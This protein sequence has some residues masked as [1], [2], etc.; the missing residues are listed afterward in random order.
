MEESKL[1]GF[2]L[3]LL[4]FGAAV[5]IAEIMTGSLIAPLGLKQGLLVIILGHLI[6][7]LI[8]AVTGVIG[9]KE[10]KPSLMATRFSMGTYGSYLISLFNIIQ[11]I[12][13]TAIMI[14]QGSR[15]LQPVTTQLLGFDNFTVLVIFMGVLI[16]IWA[17]TRD[18]GVNII[19]NIAVFLLLILC[20]VMFGTILGSGEMQTVAGSISFGA[21]L[22]LSIIMPLSWIPLISDYTCSGKTLKGSFWG[23]FIGY[24]VGS[25]F[26]YTIGL[27]LALCTGSSD[28]IAALSSFNMAFAALLI[29]VLSTATT[30]FLDVYSAVMSTLNLAPQLS[31]RGLIVLFALLGITLALFFPIENYENFLYMIG[32]IFAPA[33]TVVITDYFIYRKDRSGSLLN[34][35]GLAAMGVGVFTYYTVL[36]MD[37]MVGS[38]IPAMLVTMLV[39]VVIRSLSRAGAKS[40]ET[41]KAAGH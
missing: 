30:T 15:A 34:I 33:F 37:L 5:S 25:T 31:R 17:L 23:S 4:W 6:G 12:G 13:W 28:P 21:A 24:F 40:A 27:L 8:L 10:K 11:L 2:N 14:I 16:G 29:V 36:P 41:E 7:T 32:S 22:E 38:T 35:G 20:V 9:F 19:N 1:S 3:S 18:S 26:M 39:Y